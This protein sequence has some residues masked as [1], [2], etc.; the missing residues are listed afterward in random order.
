MANMQGGC[1]QHLPCMLYLEGI[2]LSSLKF[3]LLSTKALTEEWLESTDEGGRVVHIYFG[4]GFLT[5]EAA[6][7]RG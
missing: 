3:L 6:N 1:I 5:F 4:E 2:I 7:V